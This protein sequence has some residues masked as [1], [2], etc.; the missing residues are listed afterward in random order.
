MG[1]PTG[2]ILCVKEIKGVIDKGDVLLLVSSGKR[3]IDGFN[4]FSISV[5]QDDGLWKTVKW[6]IVS[7]AKRWVHGPP[8][9]QVEGAREESQA[10]AG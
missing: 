1:K 5:G 6:G 8:C 9:P 10:V 2:R 7:A 4:H 3:K